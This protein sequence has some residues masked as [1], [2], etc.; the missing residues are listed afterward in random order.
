M[1]RDKSDVFLNN[2]SQMSVKLNT[3]TTQS[4]TNDRT[5][6]TASTYKESETQRYN[7]CQTN[8]LK[9]RVE[10]LEQSLLSLKQQQGQELKVV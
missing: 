4:M 8:L 7:T 1:R 3:T 2:S 9:N 5:H 10:E 6:N